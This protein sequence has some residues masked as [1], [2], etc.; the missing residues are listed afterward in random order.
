MP[1]RTA[2]VLNDSEFAVD[3]DG[4]FELVIGGEPR[5]GGWLA[6]S[7][8]ASR[9]TVRHYWEDLVPP[10]TPPAPSLGLSIEL[11]DG[12]VP[13]VPLPPNDE[14]VTAS[15]HRLARFV[16][17]R[18]IESLQPP[19]AADPPGFVSRVPNEFPRPVPPG[20]HALAAADATYAMAVDYLRG[21]VG[22]NREQAVTDPDGVATVV[23]AHRDPGV[24]NWLTTEGRPFGL[25]FWRFLLVDGP[26]EPITAR[27]VPVSSLS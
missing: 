3:A 27:V 2:G 18:T 7:A 8:D 5:D 21:R 15:I 22:L 20:D 1:T 24:P 4:E 17:S 26:V 19:G 14:S 13:A 11:I 9:I 6:L 10:S 16:R 23:I 25:V 12:D